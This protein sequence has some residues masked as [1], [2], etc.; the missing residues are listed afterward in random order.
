MAAKSK[1]PT[2]ANQIVTI[3]NKFPAGTIDEHLDIRKGKGIA[4]NIRSV[5]QRKLSD[6]ISEQIPGFSKALSADQKEFF[7]EPQAA[8][9][10]V[11]DITDFM[12]LTSIQLKQSAVIKNQALA[13]QE[14][15]V[16][17]I[18]GAETID[19]TGLSISKSE[20]PSQ[21]AA[22]AAEADKRGQTGVAGEDAINLIFNN[23]VFRN[24]KNHLIDRA[25]EK[26]ENLLLINTVDAD[27]SPKF[28]L[29]FIV[30]PTSKL[31][32]I[33][34]FSGIFS[35]YY[36]INIT[37]KPERRKEFGEAPE[38]T[39]EKKVYNKGPTRFKIQLKTKAKLI[40]DIKKRQQNITNDVM[41]LMKG[42]K[43]S[44]ELLNYFEKQ[45][46]TT[47]S[48]KQAGQYLSLAIGF[49]KEFERGG[50]TPLVIRAELQS[51]LPQRIRKMNGK[52]RGPGITPEKPQKFI[53]GA[54]ITSLVQN[55]LRK[56]MPQG[57]RRGPPLS[58]VTMTNRT[59]R[60]RRSID[61]VPIYRANIMK[62][63]Y[64]PIYMSLLDTP[65]NPDNLI[66][67]TVREVVQKLFSRQFA[68]T[69]GM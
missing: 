62:Y 56:I 6:Y 45:I 54:Q 55:R 40:T 66:S 68:V 46:P 52:V 20:R 2:V 15:K 18:S 42:K 50:L 12:K 34:Y 33:R 44:E 25:A 29:G 3:T 69:R 23:S 37:L 22:I 39:P 19:I 48:K 60:F 21:F 35:Q 36:S 49:A 8:P 38:S 16:T 11:L 14:A 7:K 58:P 59:G 10:G 53:S 43:F 13:A 24:I 41:S 17:G 27:K 26:L 1:T 30:D 28:T 57:P 64:D 32:N 4:S 63:T 65:Y 67:N 61:I 5:V 47:F 9:D 31:P 51:N